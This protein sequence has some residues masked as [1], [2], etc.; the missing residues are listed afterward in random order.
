MPWRLCRRRGIEVER[1]LSHVSLFTGVGG[2]DYAAEKA[3]FK[4]V[5]Q[6]ERD[7]YC[8]GVLR[9]HWPEVYRCTD[10]RRFP[11]REF[12][13]VTLISGGDPCPVRSRARSNHGTKHP[14]LSGYFLAVVAA[15]RPRWVVR[16][17][18]P[19]PDVGDFEAAL[20]VLGYRCVIVRTDAASFTGQARV[21]DFLVGST[22]ETWPSRAWGLFK[23]ASSSRLIEEKREPGTFVPCLTTHPQRYDTRDGYV[24]DGQFRVLD[25]TERVRFSGF[26]QGWLD[27]LSRRGVAKLTGNAVV[28]QQV[29][30]ILRAIAEIEIEG[31]KEARG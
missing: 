19:A 27:G 7:P 22:D 20:D 21:R 8:L 12:G 2:I 4:T 9:R 28:P 14:D 30:P 26:P 18:V 6:V 1:A 15:I 3:G 11:D 24:W 31:D 29:Y 17:N 23:Y 5:A 25:S 10:I 16:E 13:P